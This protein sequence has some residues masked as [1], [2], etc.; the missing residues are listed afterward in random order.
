MEIILLERIHHLGNLGDKVKVKAGFGRNYLIPQG[1]AVPANA[2]N[3]AKFEARRAELEKLEQEKLTA[4]E[5]RAAQLNELTVSIACLAS[6]EGKLY[7]SVGTKEIADAINSNS[8]AK[9]EKHEVLLS[10]GVIRQLGEYQIKVQ[11]HSD[12]N[13]TVTI[14]IN[15]E[16]KAEQ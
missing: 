1:K 7:G 3:I 10:D 4:A 8:E 14:N 6:E 15:A 11:L 13:A 2:A 16:T 5:Q 9:I 12:I